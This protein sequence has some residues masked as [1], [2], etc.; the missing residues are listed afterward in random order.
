M[1][2]YVF[3]P[4][5]LSRRKY[6]GN[7]CDGLE[8]VAIKLRGT[9]WMV[10]DIVPSRNLDGTELAMPYFI[11][12]HK[13]AAEVEWQF[14]DEFC[15]VIE[16]K[17]PNQRLL[18]FFSLDPISLSL[19]EKEVE[20]GNGVLVNKN[21]TKLWEHPRYQAHDR[22][23][24]QTLSLLNLFRTH[25]TAFH[26]KYPHIGRQA[27]DL[28]TRV[29]NLIRV[30]YKESA[31]WRTLCLL[32]LY[33]TVI[34][35]QFSLY[36]YNALNWRR[37]K[38]VAFSAMAQQ[39][40]LRC[41]QTCYFPVQYLRINMNMSLR[42]ALPR[43]RTYSEA[44]ATLR[45]DLPSNYYPDYIRFY[46]TV[47]LFLND[48]SFGLIFAAFLFEWS[49]RLTRLLSKII[50]FFLY[51]MLKTVTSSLANNPLGI[52]LNEELARFLSDLFLWIIEF[53]H[54]NLIQP[55]VKPDNLSMFLRLVGNLGC[56]FGG[57]F[58][59]SVI[60]DFF[61]ILTLHIYVFYHI[62]GKIYH[63]QLQIMKSLFHLFCGK[64]RNVLRNRVDNNVFELDELLLGTLFFIILVF[65]AP[66]VLA[67]YYSFTAFRLTTIFIQ[68]G[69]ESVIALLNHFPLFAL[70]LR[71]KDPRRI[72]G[73]ISIEQTDG[74]S[75]L[76]LKN[77]PLSVGSMFS[78]YLALIHQMKDTYLS[79]RT[80]KQVLLG[81]P[82]AMHRNNLYQL[83]YSSLPSKPIKIATIYDKLSALVSSS[84]DL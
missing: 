32:G 22:R 62:S 83:L 4:Q 33:L 34:V 21:V 13:Q 24:R 74:S 15:S 38:L 1:A 43:F 66:T 61:S 77:R 29:L 6:D 41:Q 42:K 80:F 65:L 5:H 20:T 11:I 56:C 73:G 70:L 76:E 3:W 75:R 59:F 7:G 60:L 78:P 55:L 14:E 69:L 40:D 25:E 67:F 54:A 81:E 39:I 50:D 45:K 16:F 26:E 46:N 71:L 64:K 52:K 31:V 30:Q 53:S 28:S 82:L 44:S 2:G 68:I 84:K 18:Q 79:A 35:C 12:A 49:E 48:I 19:P 47:W 9:D 17:A 37:M 63:W 57:A 58:A 51:D 10:V 72:P 27:E 36:T 8:A 23:L